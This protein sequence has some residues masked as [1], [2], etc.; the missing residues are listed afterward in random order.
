MTQ[1]DLIILLIAGIAGTF[2]LK[3]S[4][5]TQVISIGWLIFAVWVIL[6]LI[7]VLA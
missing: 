1:T 2:T 6:K 7:H 3:H 4:L 5:G